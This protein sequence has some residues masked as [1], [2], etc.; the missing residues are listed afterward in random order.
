MQD[1]I[2]ILVIDDD[3]ALLI[4]ISEMF[5]R[6]GY[7]TFSASNGKQGIQLAS[8]TSPHLI[9]CD[10]MMP[11]P[12]GIQV[13]K[14]LS[15]NPSTAYIPFVF[16]TARSGESNIIQGLEL[17]AD[18]YISKPFTKG[19]LLARIRAIL[20]R[21]GIAQ[22]EE[23]N[24]A[25]EEIASLRA[26]IAD[27]VERFSADHSSLAEAMA[28]MLALRDHITDEHGRRVVELSEKVATALG[29]EANEVEQLRIGALLHDI[30]KI[31]IPDAILHKPG[32]LS[33]DERATMKQHVI[34]G[35]QIAQSI[36]LKQA[37]L[38]LIRHH[39]EQWN[40]N[41]YPDGLK[42]MNI[43]TVARIF[44]VVDVWDALTSDRPY[45]GAWSVEKAK[46]YLIAQS[47]IQ[48]DPHIV[49]EFLKILD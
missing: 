7:E 9:I 39:H 45:R 8:E 46:E 3:K 38:E 43:P 11:P 13:I 32:E 21:K 28:R 49:S 1:S 42:G 30:G 10:M 29:L 40:G 27:L 37:A 6:E 25:E 48:F 31:G 14:T 47:G 5:K 22:A 2:R 12:D 4:G 35:H 36:G 41:G 20:R 23:R 44:A 16:L 19:E 34:L 33:V 24:K 17:G 26:M 15:E 18:D